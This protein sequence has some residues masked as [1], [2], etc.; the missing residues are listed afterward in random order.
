M[1]VYRFRVL[2]DYEEDV[3]RDIE[4]REDQTFLELHLSIQEAFEFDGQQLASFYKSN[5]TWDKGEEIPLMDFQEDF[6]PEKLKTMEETKLSDM[7]EEESQKLL[8]VF[9]FMLM[10][11]FF[12]EIL[13]IGE[14]EELEYP[15]LVHE[16]GDSPDQY[17]KESPVLSEDEV[18]QLMKEPEDLDDEIGGMFSELEGED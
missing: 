8:Y 14:A 18:D 6:G 7:I 15:M 3:F 16:Y 11:C 2:I 9:D 5:E 4:L 13:K 1:K 10:W 17:G 12:I